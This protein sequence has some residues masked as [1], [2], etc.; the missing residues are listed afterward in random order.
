MYSRKY[1]ATGDEMPGKDPKKPAEPKPDP[2][3][4]KGSGDE[5]E[6]WQVDGKF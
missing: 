6:P 4:R 2:D 3:D 1:L 5:N